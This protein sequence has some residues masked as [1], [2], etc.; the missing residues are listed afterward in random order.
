MKRLPSS[1]ALNQNYVFKYLIAKSGNMI[2]FSCTSQDGCTFY[3]WDIF[4]GKRVDMWVLSW[5][6]TFARKFVSL[7]TFPTWLIRNAQLF[8]LH[9]LKSGCTVF[10]SSFVFLSTKWLK[11]E[12]SVGLEHLHGNS[13]RQ[14]K[15]GCGGNLIESGQ[16]TFI[17]MQIFSSDPKCVSSQP[18][19]SDIV[20][21]S[22]RVP[23]FASLLRQ[24]TDQRMHYVRG[25]KWRCSYCRNGEAF[26]YFTE[27]R[28]VTLS[29]CL[30]LQVLHKQGRYCHS[31]KVG[32]YKILM[33]YFI[34]NGKWFFMQMTKFKL[35]S[36]TC[37]YFY[38]IILIV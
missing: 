33:H 36:K 28:I 34:V 12:F 5:H 26:W 21:H 1:S 17:S 38:Y 19:V 3:P 10:A 31:G 24:F 25:M 22:A 7:P 32:R 30:F 6:W 29:Q 16:R 23:D 35:G 11:Y 18:H 14:P 13:F 2:L 9:S 27:E 4:L 8:T 15:K 37:V 20:D